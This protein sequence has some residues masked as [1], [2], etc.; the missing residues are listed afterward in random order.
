VVVGDA[1]VPSFGEANPAY[2]A[3]KLKARLSTYSRF[4]GNGPWEYGYRLV[5]DISA[6]YAARGYRHDEVQ[7]A[8]DPSLWTFLFHA[9]VLWHSIDGL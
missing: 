8:L 9:Q 2:F 7:Q 4:A 5:N 3:K 1:A 6:Y